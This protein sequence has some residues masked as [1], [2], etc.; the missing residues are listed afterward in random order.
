MSITIGTFNL[1]NLFSRFDFQAEIDQIPTNDTG[2][3]TL[4]FEQGQFTART[5]MGRLVRAKDPEDT[6]KIALRITEVTAPAARVWW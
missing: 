3:I 5:F 2:G 1:N 4:T 6:S